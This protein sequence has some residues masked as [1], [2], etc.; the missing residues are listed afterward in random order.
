[1]RYEDRDGND[2]DAKMTPMIDVVF[3]LLIFFLL[4]FQIIAPEGDLRIHMPQAAA[5][6]I[7][8]IPPAPL[9]IRIT[10]QADRQGELA[11]IHMGE[12][13]VADFDQLRRE[14][15]RL[16]N[17]DHG[18]ASTAAGAEVE[19]QCDR[20]LRFEHTMHAVTSVSGYVDR[21]RIVPLVE[22]IRFTPKSEI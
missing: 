18:H 6:T 15:R 16:V 3:L 20:N 11:A 7:D 9:L 17:D 2:P 12:R 14:V 13:K 4:T 19:L 1:M 22:K 8:A 10:L 5:E 21:H